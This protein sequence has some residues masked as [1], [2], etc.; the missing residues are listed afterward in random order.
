MWRFPFKGWQKGTLINEQLL[1][2]YWI[3][4]NIFMVQNILSSLKMEHL[5]NL[6]ERQIILHQIFH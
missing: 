3:G 6:Y 1:V 2:D 5:P 4:V